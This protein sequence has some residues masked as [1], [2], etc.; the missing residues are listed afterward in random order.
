M[1]KSS[2]FDRLGTS[3]PRE[4]VFNRLSI[5]LPTKEGTLR[6]CRSAFDRL[7]STSNL[8]DISQPKKGKNGLQKR[9]DTE[10]Y[11]LIPSHM[12]HELIVE[13][14]TRNSFKVKRRTIV[15]TRELEKQ[16]NDGE[17]DHETLVLPS[18]HV[19]AETDF[20]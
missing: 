14:S 17:E 3:T 15:H 1:S 19:T 6:A 11:S 20:E 16:V 2:V 5:S 9:N 10:A 7:G 18:C 4:S 8:T 13:V 12:K